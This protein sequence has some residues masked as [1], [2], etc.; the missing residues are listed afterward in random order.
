[1]S[2]F[3]SRVRAAAGLAPFAI[4]LALTALVI[5]PQ[6]LQA[7]Q[8][9]LPL[10]ATIPVDPA[11]T[12]GTLPNG[13]KYYIRK[14]AKPEQRAELR[15]VVN[16]GSVLEA[17]DQRGLAHF[18]EHMAFNGTKNFPKQA[19]VQFLESVGMTF[20]ADVNAQTG[21]DETIFMLQVPTDKPEVLDRSMLILED[22]AHNVSFDADEV[23]KER[24]VVLEEWRLGRGAQAR[25]QDKQFP[26]LLKG[27]RYAERLPIG[28][29]E[30]LRTF[31]HDRLKQFY[32][33]W[34]R[35]DLMA[36]VAVGD[37]DASAVEALVKKHF[38]PIPP[39]PASAKPRPEFTVPPQPGTRFAVASDT[40][41]PNTS[42][43]VYA[44]YRAAD[45]STVGDYRRSI[46]NS[47]FGGMLSARF[48]E[49]AQ[50]PDAPFLAAG[51]SRGS[52]VRSTDATTL[53]ALVKE[54]G[55]AKGL[56]AL[57]TETARVASF[58]FTQTELDR[59]KQNA[60]RAMERAAAEKDKQ[61]SGPLAD[62]YVRNFTTGEPIPGIAF[63]QRLY[64]RF[65]PEVSLAELNTLAKSWMPVD[66]RI[67]V[68]S[69]PEKA[70]LA[71]PTPD[72]LGKVIAAAGAAP[73]TAYEDKV[74]TAPFFDAAPKAGSIVKTET[75]PATGI[76]EWTLSNG[77]RVVIKPTDFKED[78]VLFRAYSPGGTSLASDAN[79]VPASTAAGVVAA[80]GL[81]QLSS[82]ELRKT[83]AGKIANVTPYIDELFEGLSGG[84]SPKDLE[85]L[86]QLIYLRF[87][88]PRPDPAMFNTIVTQSRAVLANQA[89]QP[90][91]AFFT[92]LQ[93]IMTMDHPRSQPTT[94]ATLDQMDLDKSLAFYK[95]RFADASDFTFVFVGSVTPDT[96]R[97]FVEKYVASLPATH[98]TET[99]KDVGR[100]T[101]DK[102]VV[103]T[104]E[105][106]LEP[107]AQSEIVFTGP[108]V[109][110]QTQRVAMRA[111]SY[112]LEKR[113]RERLREDLGGTYSVG[114]SGNLSRDPRQEYV[115]E[116]QFGADP[117]R[118]D[119]LQATVFDEI[120]KLKASGPTDVELA[121]ARETFLRDFDQSLK[122]NA[123]WLQQVFYKYQYGEDPATLLNVPDYYKKIDA[124]MVTQAA[125]T[126]LDTNRYV[127]VTLKPEKKNPQ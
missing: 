125:K 116:I 105:K 64:E 17:D 62:E 38:T 43:E 89:A 37:F 11:I 47:L 121:D 40:E 76:T 10:G 21:F 85:T 84:G 12:T 2:M 55:I 80:G 73:M 3:R 30:I 51:T 18:V 118:I 88:E 54:D 77:A 53:G 87:T 33:D 109:Y 81:G 79:Y 104:V 123:F 120:A 6:G 29:P 74:G 69:A 44:T 24:G 103:E 119:A 108:A 111:L 93:K 56:S 9:P 25:L 27:S 98:R 65:V 86:F 82:V 127:K 14:N 83:L 28:D 59:A 113:L 90:E 23:D 34:Y 106:G 60:L 20:G 114:A 50:K 70:G 115:F 96:L 31:K 67:V 45:Q 4:A 58:G 41:M 126:Y 68:V 39:A 26:V 95:D 36:V 71:L 52:F 1:M 99:W 124:A 15:L 13:L 48:S 92:T 112:V 63:E 61:P 66:G 57:F 101:P 22:W 94:V 8:A 16:A 100:R 19:L 107:K 42:V 117:S 110:D 122:S 7:Q 49:M 97:P 72:E 32:K 35:P 46:V 91:Y 75:A 102:I 5:R 78:E